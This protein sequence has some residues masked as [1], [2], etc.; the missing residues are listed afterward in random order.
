[1]TM[2]GKFLLF[3]IG[4]GRYAVAV[5]D[6]ERIVAAAEVTPLPDAREAV[7]GL[8]NIAGEIMPVVDTRRQL[9]LPPREMELSDRFIVTRAAGKPLALLVETVEE[10]VALPAQSITAGNGADAWSASAAVGVGGGIV[11]IYRIEALVA[12]DDLAKLE[13]SGRDTHA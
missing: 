5:A 8:I 13:N 12:A 4:G 10:V 6:V 9:G 11:V 3:G 7:L 1:M 2:T